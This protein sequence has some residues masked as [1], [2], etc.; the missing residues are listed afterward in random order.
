[1]F[2]PQ[3][4]STQNDELKFCKQCGAN[5]HALRRVM[6]SRDESD[7]KFDWS[8]TWVA[9]MFMS[10]AESAK[11]QAALDRL[12]GVTPEIK[13]QNEIK[14]GV[15]TGCVGVGLM[16]FLYVFMQGLIASGAV[17]DIAAVILSRV[18]LVG[19]IPV[20]VGAALIFNGVFVSKRHSGET[21]HETASPETPTP[22][23]SGST[24]YLSPADT[25]ELASAVPFSITDETTK[26][27]V[28]RSGE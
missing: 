23:I 24:P 22:L 18:W 27:L 5:L 26:N 14:G 28:K 4:G 12:R 3:C 8:K 17:S 7:D 20:L 6:A 15:I 19:I 1:M 10:E 16:I 21:A 11:R 25:T 9:E 2:C 13:R